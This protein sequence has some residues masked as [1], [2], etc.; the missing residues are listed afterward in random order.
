MIS[1][2]VLGSRE[3]VGSS[4]GRR[5]GFCISAPPVIDTVA[6]LPRPPARHPYP[7]FQDFEPLTRVVAV[8]RIELTG[9]GAPHGS[10]R[11][12]VA[13]AA[14]PAMFSTDVGRIE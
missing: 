1:T 9:M 7:P 3:E 11:S 6:E 2:E 8:A 5:S 4:A 13:L 12:V 10:W 14:G